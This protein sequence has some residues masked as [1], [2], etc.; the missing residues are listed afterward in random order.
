[1]IGLLVRPVALVLASNLVV[2]VATAGRIDGGAVNLGLAPAL[3]VVLAALAL[4]G[5]GRYSLDRRLARSGSAAAYS[6][7]MSIF[8]ISSI[9]AIARCARSSSGSRMSS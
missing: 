1:M 5:G 2:A 6:A 8:P 4:W 7:A 9:A 3:I